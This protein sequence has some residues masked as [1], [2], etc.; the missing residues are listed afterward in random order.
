[1][2]YR[3]EHGKTTVA[4][5]RL[6]LGA[7][8][9]DYFHNGGFH[10]L[11]GEDFDGLFQLNAT[12]ETLPFLPYTEFAKFPV[13]RACE[14]QQ[15]SVAETLLSRHLA[16]KP[17]SN[18][19]RVFAQVFPVQATRLAEREFAYFHKYAFNTLRQLGANFELLASHLGWLDDGAGHYSQAA[20]EALKIAEN[21]KSVQF[22]LARALTR[23]KFETLG[24]SLD[25]AI[26]AWDALMADLSAR[27]ANQR[28]AA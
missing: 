24:A 18:P 11:S 17:E 22:Q 15:R 9:L 19:V 27:F 7:K 14:R 6:D 2:A 25:P 21:A 20:S 13:E 1:V 4:I 8:Q 3:L 23:K 28:E 26:A 5:N 10:S 12:P 16:R